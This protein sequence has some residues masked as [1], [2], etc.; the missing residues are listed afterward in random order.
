MT[1]DGSHRMR[2]LM[3]CAP[4]APFTDSGGPVSTM[5][6]AGENRHEIHE[7]RPVDRLRSL[8]IGRS[9]RLPLRSAEEWTSHA[10]LAIRASTLSLA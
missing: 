2:I 10:A 6:V 1:R 8:D 4:V 5:V 9:Y 3:A 7:G